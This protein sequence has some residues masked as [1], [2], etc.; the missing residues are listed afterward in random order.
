MFGEVL[1]VYVVASYIVPGS[2]LGLPQVLIC[3][4]GFAD[5]LPDEEVAA[6]V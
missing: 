6:G 1:L 5:P 3:L 4:S 2:F